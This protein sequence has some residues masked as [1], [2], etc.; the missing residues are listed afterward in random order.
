MSNR[1]GQSPHHHESYVRSRTTSAIHGSARQVDV[2]L[3]RISIGTSILDSAAIE[4][5][6]RIRIEKRL[7]DYY[8]DFL[9]DS[10][11][12]K[13]L[14]QSNYIAAITED[15]ASIAVHASLLL[16]DQLIFRAFEDA[17]IDAEL[18]ALTEMRRKGWH[19]H[20][21]SMRRGP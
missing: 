12:I 15:A 6:L 14:P 13:D 17:L 9:N 3:D 1:R 2:V 10:N 19:S 4:R 18:R 5:I 21:R 7:L 11:M 16:S 20:P 8:E